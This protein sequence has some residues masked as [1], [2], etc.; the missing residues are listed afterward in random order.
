MTTLYRIID[1]PV[2]DIMLVGT[3]DAANGFL[4]SGLYLIG[5]KYE[6]AVGA[7]WRAGGA[8]FDIFESRLKAYFAGEPIAFGLDFLLRGSEFQQR[9]WRGLAD[10]PYG[11]TVTYGALAE[12]VADR[13]KTRAV[14]A[15]VG[16]NP[17]SIMVPCH[18]VI[19]ASGSLTG[20]A[21]G[22]DRKRWLLD[23]EAAAVGSMLALT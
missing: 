22:L 20:Y 3:D 6:P 17:V 21:G 11:T 16:R 18:R 8:E 15:A 14:A 5:Q 23:H 2:R 19:G 4:L 12:R 9:V 13:T 1:S 7:D 10:I